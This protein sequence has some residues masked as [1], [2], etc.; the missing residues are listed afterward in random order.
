MKTEEE[1]AIQL[2]TCL[3]QEGWEAYLAGGAAR[4]LLIGHQPKDF[5]IVTEAP[6]P[7]VKQLFQ[8]RKVSLVGESFKVCIVDDIE[9]ATFRKDTYLGLS[10]RNAVIEEAKTI[11]E[12]LARRDFTINSMAF[13]PY[14]GDVIDVYG[15]Q[16]DLQKRIIRF[17]GDPVKR[18]FEDPCRILRACR[19]V[20]KIEGRFEPETLQALRT[21]APFVKTHVAPERIRLELLKA[22]QCRKPSLFFDALYDIGVLKYV[23][24]GLHECYGQD[25]G[26][27]HAESVDVHCKLAGDALSPKNS[28][29]RLAGYFH[30]IGKPA[31]AVYENGQ[32]R[33]LGHQKVGA[34]IVAD[35]LKQLRFS[36][37]EVA[38]ITGLVRLHMRKIEASTAPK[39][40]R[41]IFRSLKDR[42]IPWKDWFRLGLADVACNLKKGRVDRLEIKT[43]VLKINDAVNSRV[44]NAA[45][46]IKELAING[47]DVMEVFGIPPGPEVG[48]VLNQLLEMAIDEPELNTKDKLMKT[49]ES[50]I[51]QNGILSDIY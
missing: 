16:Q 10:A 37:K 4:D 24:K 30:D 9:I 5:D 8:N 38:Y 13:C 23:S 31:T 26:L 21:Y 35:E 27:H 51:I 14:S 46:C 40:I 6:Y 32:L 36:A 49:V 7:V 20:A 50:S 44:G 11:Q 25:G 47:R 17:T 1:R 41:R 33:F 2:I 34:E 43:A 12:D 48:Q 15:G 18:I 19:F 28:L 29:L 3:C 22:M 42:Q 39:A 45:L